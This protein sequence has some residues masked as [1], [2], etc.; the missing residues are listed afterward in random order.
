[1][2]IRSNKRKLAKV[3][4]VL[5]LVVAFSLPQVSSL[6]LAQADTTSAERAQAVAQTSQP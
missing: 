1:M 5:L 6:R 4:I 3:C 2:L